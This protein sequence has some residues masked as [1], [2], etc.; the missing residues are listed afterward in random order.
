VTSHLDVVFLDVGGPLYSD[1]PYY[2]GLLAAI[3]EAHPEVSDDE[4]WAELT[5]CRQDQRGPFTRRLVLRFADEDEYRAVVDRGKELWSYPPESLQPDVMPALE[6]LAERYR[7]GV[8]ANQE[9]W[10][11]DVMA[12]D[13]LDRF[14]D[15]WAVSAEIGADKPDPALFRHALAEADTPAERCVMVGDR[16]DNDV[17]PARELGMRTV[18]LLRGEAPDDPTPEQLSGADA[19]VRTLEEVPEALARLPAAR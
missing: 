13:G 1:R 7:L 14:F 3:K 5:A 9:P 11:R 4:F 16:L 8:L 17:V 2:Q 15:V 19:A 10:I 6:A 18:W 12:R